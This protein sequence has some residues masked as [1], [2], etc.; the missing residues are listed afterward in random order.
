MQ[1]P[2]VRPSAPVDGRP[3][4][5]ASDHCTLCP[6][7]S[8]GTALNTVYP[9]IREKVELRSG[10]LATEVHVGGRRVEG[11]TV[12]DRDGKPSRVSAR[13]VVIAANGV[14]SCL[15]LQRSA[16][17]PKHPTLGCCYMDHP[18]FDVA[19]YGTGLDARPGYGNSAQTG[20]I[21]A[22]FERA[23]EALPVSLL[24]EI[25]FADPVNLTDTRAAV[26]AD[27]ARF[28]LQRRYSSAASVRARFE[29]IWRSTLFLKFMVETQPVMENTV[30]IAEI[31]PGGQAIPS[32]ALRLPAYFDDCLRH[33]RADLQARLPQSTIRHIV[34]RPGAHHWMGATRMS[35]NP[36]DGCVDANLRYHGL[37]NLS[38]LSASAFPS[39]SSANP[40][41]TL[42][43]LALRLGDHLA[44]I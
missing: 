33:V 9:A 24:G 2:T 40:T 20:M 14:D 34:T 43:A 26:S 13:H 19:I 35:D 30:S 41:L 8:K 39:C 15:L 1:V 21:T 7:D 17:I 29:E 12:V 38:V 5:C 32:I 16:G 31:R 11:L 37:E 6:I 18:S 23:A 28:A 4:C 10:L 3:Q 42:C 22:F 36:R 25:R 44:A 27:V